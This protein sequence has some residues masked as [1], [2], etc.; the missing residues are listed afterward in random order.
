MEIMTEQKPVIIK[1][2]PSESLAIMST[3]VASSKIHNIDTTNKKITLKIY[4][5]FFVVI[6]EENNKVTK[7][8]FSDNWDF[9]IKG[10]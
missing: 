3:I 5:D 9:H 6:V 1:L 7:E 4:N 8:V 2:S 10:K